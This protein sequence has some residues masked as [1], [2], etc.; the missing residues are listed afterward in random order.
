MDAEPTEPDAPPLRVDCDTCVMQHTDACGDCLVTYLCR[1][2]PHGA[3]VITI[4]EL[5]A[6]RTLAQGGLVP[7]LRHRTSTVGGEGAP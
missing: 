4:E 6:M 3:V 7:E 1:P 5:R 2:E